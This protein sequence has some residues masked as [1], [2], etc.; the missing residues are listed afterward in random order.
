MSNSNLFTL[1]LVVIVVVI[2]AEY[3]A[4]DYGDLKKE[5]PGNVLNQ[6]IDVST[7]GYK[8]NGESD[9]GEFVVGGKES[10]GGSDLAGGAE[11]TG[12]AGN[13]DVPS[14]VQFEGNPKISFGLISGAGFENVSLQRYPFNGIL[15]ERVDIRDFKSVPVIL[16]RVLKNNRDVIAELYEFHAD[17]SLLAGEIYL[18][19][20]ERA[21]SVIEAGVNETDTCGDKSFFINYSDR[22]DNAFLVVKTGNSV[23][24]LTYEK[25]LHKMVE[26]VLKEI[27]LN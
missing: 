23:Y 1:F 27:S 15:F 4:N 6:S 17:S 25:G 14:A 2:I 26:N 7:L 21:I 19:I 10:A 9:G 16:Q 13:S 24:S 18:L 3:L 5:V 12:V 8:L 11:G 20:K 22:P